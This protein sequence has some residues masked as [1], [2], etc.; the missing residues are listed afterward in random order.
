M[1]S[2]H[3]SYEMAVPWGNVVKSSHSSIAPPPTNVTLSPINLKNREKVS[4]KV[5]QKLAQIDNSTDEIDGRKLVGQ[6]IQQSHS[7]DKEL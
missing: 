3:Q 5:S 6:A 1:L 7:S 4:K 2:C